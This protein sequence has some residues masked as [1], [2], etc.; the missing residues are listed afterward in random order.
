MNGTDSAPHDVVAVVIM[1][2]A[3]SGKSTAGAALAERLGWD[4]VDADELH[5]H[6]N[7]DKMRR[8]EPLDDADRV[9]WLDA[10]RAVV[11]THA[12]RGEPLVLACSALKRSY[13]CR[14]GVDRERVLLVHLDV[15]RSELERR[16]QERHG[17]FMGAAMLDSQLATLEVPDPDESLI[18]DGRA[19]IAAVV[20]QVIAHLEAAW[21]VGSPSGS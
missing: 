15:E 11:D 6:A 7:V 16:L 21:G 13:R 8:G 9:P 12:R 18:V 4:F 19:T 20:G 17:H 14:L 3:G 5:P 1:G 10:L 2:V